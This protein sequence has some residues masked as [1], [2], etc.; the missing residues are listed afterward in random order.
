[1]LT[2]PLLRAARHRYASTPAHLQVLKV[3]RAAI[4]PQEPEEQTQTA[5]VA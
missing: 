3:E 2:R 4:Q 5:Q 1:M